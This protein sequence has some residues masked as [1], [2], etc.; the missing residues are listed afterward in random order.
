MFDNESLDQGAYIAA[1]ALKSIYD[2]PDD[3]DDAPQEYVPGIYL[4]DGLSD[5]EDS[6]DEGDGPP[7]SFNKEPQSIMMP[8]EADER[9]HVKPIPKIEMMPYVT[10]VFNQLNRRDIEDLVEFDKLEEE[11]LNKNVAAILGDQEL[12]CSGLIEKAKK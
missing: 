2:G 12:D 4:E 11:N 7:E 6:E 3:D 9:K 8:P 10:N 1:E 5:S